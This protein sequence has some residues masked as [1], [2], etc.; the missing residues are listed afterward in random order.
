MRTPRTYCLLNE[1][2][3]NLVQLKQVKHPYPVLIWEEGLPFFI[4]Y[5]GVLI[6]R[7]HYIITHLRD[8][9]TPRHASVGYWCNNTGSPRNGKLL[10]EPP[11]SR[12]VCSM[13]EAK[14]V[15]AGELRSSELIGKHVHI[16]RMK[17]VRICCQESLN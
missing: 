6:H 11:E 8:D 9:G 1:V 5:R 15:A 14:A 4:N 12:L 10:A 3:M 7:V 16:G 17:P 13:C 2:T